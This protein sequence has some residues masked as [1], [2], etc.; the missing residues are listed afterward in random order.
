[1]E[2]MRAECDLSLSSRRES[3]RG[4][5][6]FEGKQHKCTR[7][8]V[9]TVSWVPPAKRCLSPAHRH[10]FQM[11]AGCACSFKPMLVLVAAG[12]QVF[13]CKQQKQQQ[14]LRCM[15]NLKLAAST[16]CRLPAP[17]VC[18]IPGNVGGQRINTQKALCQGESG[19]LHIFPW[20]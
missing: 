5:W 18:H 17:I 11:C 12:R 16:A 19:F 10:T 20:M 4:K 1:M 9:Q 2:K 15:Q 13:C 14:P 6:H 7:P 8:C 3:P